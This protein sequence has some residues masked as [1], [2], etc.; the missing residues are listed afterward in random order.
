[1]RKTASQIANEVLRKHAVEGIKMPSLGS[2]GGVKPLGNFP[3]AMKP[4]PPKPVSTTT[5]T[6]SS[7][8]SVKA[9]S[10]IADEVL[11]KVAF[12]AAVRKGAGK[13]INW[14][15]RLLTGG[16]AERKLMPTAGRSFKPIEMS[17]AGIPPTAGRSFKPI[18]MPEGDFDS[19][20]KDY[21]AKARA[22][23]PE[24]IRRVTA[25]LNYNPPP[26]PQFKLNVPF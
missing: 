20:V 23:R 9:A 26:R 13:G 24:N 15:K 10:Q 3:T 18:E 2:A 12:G 19:W 1:M 21:G 17:R 22:T 6:P 25:D 5:S 8:P 16:G 7:V 14:L 4:P 11:E